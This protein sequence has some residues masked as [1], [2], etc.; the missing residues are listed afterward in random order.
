MPASAS[1]LSMSHKADTVEELTLDFASDD[2]RAGY[3]LHRVDL[4]N[5]GTFDRQIWRLTPDGSNC[6]VTGDIGS[7]K[8]TLVDAVRS[9]EHTSELQSRGHIVCRLLLENKQVDSS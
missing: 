4:L 1:M 9:E 2:A 6:L 7:G 3:R 5:W 8:S